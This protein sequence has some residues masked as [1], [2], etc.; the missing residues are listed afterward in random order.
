MD[1]SSLNNQE[2]ESIGIQTS[3]TDDTATINMTGSPDND[4]ITISCNAILT[5]IV[6]G[7]KYKHKTSIFSASDVPT[8]E[9]QTVQFIGSLMISTWTAPWC[10]PEHHHYRVI[11]YNETTTVSSGTSDTT[12][13]SVNVSSS[14]TNY[15]VSVTVVDT[16]PMGYQSVPSNVSSLS[17][18]FEGMT[19]NNCCY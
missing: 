9:G 15:T 14:C 3:N 4:G 1:D 2:M 16:G 5:G 8:V 17:G 18:F 10:V 6:N 7:V 13:Y 19:S 11:V 12:E